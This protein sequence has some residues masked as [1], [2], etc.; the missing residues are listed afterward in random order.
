MKKIKGT[1]ALSLGFL[2]PLDSK[3]HI[4]E[5]EILGVDFYAKKDLNKFKSWI[6]YSFGEVKST[7]A[8]LNNG[9][10]FVASTNVKHAFRASLAYSTNALQISA[11]WNWRSG[12]PFTK[13]FMDPVDGLLFFESIN[14]ERLPS[15]HRMDLSSTYD[16]S[17]SKKNG[18]KGKIG[19]SIRNVYN[20]KNHLSREYSG[21]NNFNNPITVLDKYSLGFTPNFLI[22]AY[23]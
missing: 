1:T 5:Q 19:I 11:A 16:F 3:F 21:N 13:A 18:M 10:F 22:R 23:W 17:F 12:K 14:T 6:S 4:G 2:N 9:N 20:K 8:D 15:Y 7:Y